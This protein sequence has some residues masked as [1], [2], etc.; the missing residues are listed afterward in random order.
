V[1]L[2]VCDD[3]LGMSPEQQAQLFEPF[4][5]LGRERGPMLGTGIGLTIVKQLTE[6]MG[7]TLSVCSEV[8]RGS[9]FTVTL[10]AAAVTPAPAMPAG[11]GEDRMPP[12]D[13][14]GD[15]VL[16]EDNEVNALIVEA[17]LRA[18]P[19]CRLHVRTDG[20]SGVQLVRAL[21]PALVL[22]DM[23]LPDGNGVHWIGQLRADP[24]LDD[25]VVVGVSG[26]ATAETVRRARD[27][28]A[29]D[30]LFKPVNVKELLEVVDQALGASR[31]GG[32]RPDSRC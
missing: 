32:I 3:G 10:L 1:A 8:G 31:N 22:M 5:R 9:T 21:R 27:A 7:G 28:G 20:A 11:N 23:N 6:A 12:P 2:S 29:A 16:I 25:V 18:R 15:V 13:A 30:Y 4:N 24:T 26:D 14:E 19:H 17:A